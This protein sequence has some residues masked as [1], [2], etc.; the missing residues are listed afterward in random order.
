MPF[1]RRSSI[2]A[3]VS[4]IVLVAAA[5]AQPAGALDVAVVD[6]FGD[7]VAGAELVVTSVAGYRVRGVSGPAG[8]A[9]LAD[10]VFGAYGVVAVAAFGSGAAEVEVPAGGRVLL[11]TVVEA[12]SAPGLVVAPVDA[13]GLPLPGALVRLSGDG[14]V[15]EAVTGADGTVA[16][17]GL[18]T[19]PWTL[20]V[21]LPGF[22]SAQLA[23][24]VAHGAPATVTVPWPWP[25]SVTPSW[26]A[27]RAPRC[28]WPR[29]R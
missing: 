16:V 21:D 15:R 20:R 14:V 1:L 5:A 27:P 6:S 2:L 25:V 3:L 13:Q 28:V 23:A 12:D 8:R 18:R 17:D 29:R 4:S 11:R 26:S 7:P 19:G 9:V 24:V 22:V 10:L